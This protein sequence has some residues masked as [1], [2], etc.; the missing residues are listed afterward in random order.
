[1]DNNIDS[2]GQIAQG[3]KAH[4]FLGKKSEVCSMAH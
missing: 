4:N 1:M 3:L 2:S